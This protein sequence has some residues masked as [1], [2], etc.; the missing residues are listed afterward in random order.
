MHKRTKACAIPKEVKLIVYER[1]LEK[2]IFC[3]APGLPEAHV[4]PRSHG[5]LGIPQNIVT[6]CRKC[7][8]KLD[9]STHRQRMLPEAVAYL[10]SF[11]PDWKKEDYVYDK[12]DKDKAKRAIKRIKDCKNDALRKLECQKAEKDKGKPPQGFEY[13]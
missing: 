4:I 3:G 6:V 2:C 1:D 12:H 9:N 11:Y 7:H 8:D 5:G 10:K 13:L